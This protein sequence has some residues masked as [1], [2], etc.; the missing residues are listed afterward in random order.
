MD[1]LDAALESSGLHFAKALDG[2]P[3]EGIDRKLT[4]DGMSPREMLEHL[5]EC[6]LAYLDLAEG[7]KHDWGSYRA[8]EKATG[9]LTST[10]K[11]LRTRAVGVALASKDPEVRENAIHYIALHDEYHVGQLCLIRLLAEPGWNAD[12]IY[13]G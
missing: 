8:P 1:P 12:S 11:D 6:Y 7:R 4:P 10:W 13:S 9:P 5:C 2:M 3:E